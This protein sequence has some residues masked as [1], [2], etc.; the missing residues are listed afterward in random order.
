LIC[1]RPRR[2]RSKEVSRGCRDGSGRRPQTSGRRPCQQMSESSLPQIL[3]V[4]PGDCPY[5]YGAHPSKLRADRDSVPRVRAQVRSKATSES[6]PENVRCRP[7]SSGPGGSSARAGEDR[8]A[9]C[10]SPLIGKGLLILKPHFLT[11]Q[12]VRRAFS[13]K[14]RKSS[15]KPPSRLCR[16]LFLK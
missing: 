16:K 5:D 9:A 3:G 4:D 8:E 12:G 14:Y 13:R 10:K 1:T 7:R 2:P 6:R 15:L 11:K